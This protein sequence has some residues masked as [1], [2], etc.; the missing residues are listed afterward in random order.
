MGFGWTE[1]G[2]V[3]KPEGTSGSDVGRAPY[4]RG[5]PFLLSQRDEARGLDGRDDFSK[6][7]FGS[8]DHLL[9]KIKNESESATTTPDAF[10][11][12]PFSFNQQVAPLKEGEDHS[13]SN[14]QRFDPSRDLS[15]QRTGRIS[16]YDL[17]PGQAGAENFYRE[18]SQLDYGYQSSKTVFRNSPVGMG[19]TYPD[20]VVRENEANP[21]GPGQVEGYRPYDVRYF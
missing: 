19:R 12:S 21:S 9:F 10:G 20:T 16:D 2:G 18:Q 17:Q 5:P 14:T 11:D 8:Q 4:E 13:K 3:D 7:N 6:Y 15:N 1:K